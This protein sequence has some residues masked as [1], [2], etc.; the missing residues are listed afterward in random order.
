MQQFKNGIVALVLASAL[1]AC[2]TTPPDS[3]GFLTD[4]SQLKPDKH[5]NSGLLWTEVPRFNWKQDRQVQ[6]DPVVIYYHP[7]AENRAIRSDDLKMLADYFREAVI[8]E[9]QGTFAVMT[10]PGPDVLRIRAAI[11]DVV[12]ASPAVNAVTTVVA[13]VPLDLGGAAIEAE[14]LDSATGERLAAMVERKKGSPVNVVGGFTELGYAKAAF[15]EWASDLKL[16]L[17]TNP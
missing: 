2:S 12:P 4:Y 10:T 5:G 6:L 15:R 1:S 16:A 13:F 14:F 3:S 17:T 9:L 8:A 11:T 7:S